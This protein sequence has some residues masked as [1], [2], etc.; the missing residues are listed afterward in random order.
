MSGLFFSGASCPRMF[1]VFFIFIVSIL[2]LLYWCLG[3]GGSLGTYFYLGMVLYLGL[4]LRLVEYFFY[5]FLVFHFKLVGSAAVMIVITILVNFVATGLLARSI[6]LNIIRL[7]E[8]AN[9][10]FVIYEAIFGFASIFILRWGYMLGAFSSPFGWFVFLL[11]IFADVLFGLHYCIVWSMGYNDTYGKLEPHQIPESINDDATFMF[12][13]SI[14]LWVLVVV[15]FFYLWF[16][17]IFN[18]V[19]VIPVNFDRIFILLK[20]SVKFFMQFFT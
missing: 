13:V 10:D 8:D 6:Y 19:V 16:Y 18:F 9:I 7:G 14:I 3:G 2:Y 15:L 17:I 4:P 5:S 1:I 12:I 11:I 20:G